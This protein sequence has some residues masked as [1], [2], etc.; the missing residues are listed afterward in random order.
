MSNTTSPKM[1]IT[2][3]WPNYCYCSGKIQANENRRGNTKQLY[4][5]KY[6]QT[7]RLGVHFTLKQSF[8]TYIKRFFNENS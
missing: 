3:V 4:V 8:L 1:K 5:A 6:I 7:T 2:K